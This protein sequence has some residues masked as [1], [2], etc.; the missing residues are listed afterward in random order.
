MA[1]AKKVN[2]EVEVISDG[3]TRDAGRENPL[4]D[5]L[6]AKSPRKNGNWKKV[7]QEELSDLERTGKLIGYDPETGE[8]L[9]K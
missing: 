9:T 3:V 6:L 7:S 5:N 2:K 8:A 4:E 1:K